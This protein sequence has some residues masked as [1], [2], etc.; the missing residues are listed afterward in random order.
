MAANNYKAEVK[1][2]GIPDRLVEHGQP[3]ELH[4]ECGFDAA[5]IANEVRIM[6][7]AKLKS[8]LMG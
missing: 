2:L 3:K 4:K 7:K 6:M 5:G 1:I 8:E